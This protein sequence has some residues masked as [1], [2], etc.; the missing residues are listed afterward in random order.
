MTQQQLTER[1]ERIIEKANAQG[2]NLAGEWCRRA[3]RETQHPR[4]TTPTPR[5]REMVIVA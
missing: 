2:R 1:N 4:V 3:W 5:R